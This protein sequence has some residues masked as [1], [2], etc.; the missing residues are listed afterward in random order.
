[1]L[2]AYDVYNAI[3]IYACVWEET[4]PLYKS[5]FIIHTH[6]VQV[7]VYVCMFFLLLVVII[8]IFFHVTGIVDPI[9]TADKCVCVCVCSNK[10]EKR[11]TGR[12][13]VR[14]R[15]SRP[16]RSLVR[17]VISFC[18]PIT[19]IPR[20]ADRTTAHLRPSQMY[21]GSGRH[22]RRRRTRMCRS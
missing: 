7:C 11:Y 2:C 14:T 21:A 3:I 19:S 17:F 8:I 15:A 20:T 22:L 10:V 5:K 9:V 13:S 12:F 1:M 6:T 16:D 18:I 4:A